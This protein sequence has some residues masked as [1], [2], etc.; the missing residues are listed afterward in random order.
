MQLVERHLIR[1]DDPQYGVIDQAA[2]A[3]KNLYNQ[4]NYQIRQSFIHEGKYLPYPRIFQRLKH[5]DC[6][7][8]LP[9]KVS[10]SILIQLHKNWLSFF[11]AMEAYREDPTPFTGRPRLPGYKDKEKGR[12]ILIYDKQAL[13][14]RAFKKTGK[15][16]PSGLPMAIATKITDWE[17][18]AQVRIVPRLDGYMVEVVYEKEEQPA[19]V[20]QSLI[21]ALDLGVNVLAALTS[22][23]SGFVA[24]LVSGKPIKS[25]NQ[26]YNKQRAVHQ[27]RLSHENRFT[28][29]H[30]DRVTTKRNR[31]VDS[32]LH[33]ASRRIIDLLVA[34]GIG[35]LVIGKN[36][37]W[38]QEANMGKRNN[39]QFVQIPHARFIDQL[40]YKARLVGIQ[41]ILQEESYTSK[42]SFLDSDPIPTYQANRPE[43]PVF[44]G[45]RIAR[46]WY[47]ASD[48]T[49]IH[50][51]INGSLNILRKSTSDLLQVGRGVAGAA[52]RPRRLAV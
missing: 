27:S 2:F 38:K 16:V 49:I 12:N 39:Q 50:A 15:L 35:T 3:S 41:V 25:L 21:A 17:K 18:I 7:R 44:S 19:Q 43:K 8:A 22:N 47:R 29:R 40:T 48:G 31:R 23:T 9:R 4:A 34:E 51:D 1:K 14:K 36:P 32:Y 5:H 6:Y 13:G 30:L 42:A 52:V 28:S 10:N 33:T 26:Y 45:T 11:E 37:L 46:S 24:R 20:N